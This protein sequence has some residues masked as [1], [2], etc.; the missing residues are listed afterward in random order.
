LRSW[1]EK[2]GHRGRT[3]A[4]GR[5]VV[6]GAEGED[7]GEFRL[8]RCVAAR[9]VES[10]AVEEEDIARFELSFHALFDESGVF[11]KF[12]PQKEVVVEPGAGERHSLG[13]WDE[14]QAA[15]FFRFVTEGEPDA[16]EFGPLVRPVAD[17]LMP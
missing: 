15:V 11:R 13:A 12:G 5:R 16:D 17:V 3:T 7:D 1:E 10:A 8:G 14:I 4:G 9:G 6:G 2:L